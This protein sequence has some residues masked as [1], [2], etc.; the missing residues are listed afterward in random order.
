MEDFLSLIK[1]LK[2][3]ERPVIEP[4]LQKLSVEKQRELKCGSELYH[5]ALEVASNSYNVYSSTENNLEPFRA[6]ECR[7]YRQPLKF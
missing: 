3:R 4:D 2:A 1:R 6:R 5:I 7:A